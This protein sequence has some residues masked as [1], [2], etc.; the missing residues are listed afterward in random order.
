MDV[1]RDARGSFVKTFQ[2]DLFQAHGLVTEFAEE[3]YSTSRQNVLRGLHFQLPPHD[4]VKL[5]GCLDGEVMDAVLDLR[6]GSPTYGR[7]VHTRLRADD[8]VWVYLPRGLAHGFYTLSATALMAYKT[9]TAYA[10]THD[11]GVLWNSA[12]I[13]WPCEM[14]ILSDRDRQHAPFAQFL[15]PFVFNVG[16][17]GRTP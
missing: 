5:V 9:S 17:S 2:K 4:H 16:A 10:P 8:G 13:P 14:P 12:G 11:A 15:T 6:S 3:Y 7:H 1:R